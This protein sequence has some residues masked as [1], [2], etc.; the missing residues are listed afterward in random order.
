MDAQYG[1][2]PVDPGR[3]VSKPEVEVTWIRTD[4]DA[5][6]AAKAIVAVLLGVP[7]EE[8]PPA[9]REL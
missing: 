7:A 6:A 2:R 8:R 9:E 3:A 1:E 5:D 4:D